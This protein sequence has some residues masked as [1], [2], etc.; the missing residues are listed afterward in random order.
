M[1]SKIN[2]MSSWLPLVFYAE[3][4]IADL[5]YSAN[6]F[7]CLGFQSISNYQRS[8]GACSNP[9]DQCFS[10]F[11]EVWNTFLSQNSSADHLTLVP[12]ERKFVNFVAYFK[13]AMVEIS[14]YYNC[15]HTHSSYNNYT[16]C[17]VSL[18]SLTY[19]LSNDFLFLKIRTYIKNLSPH[20]L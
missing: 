19:F 4:R 3:L 15:W 13:R 17:K 9:L 20:K 2:K 16:C 1:T 14:N 8:G 18:M 12:F 7:A 6:M 5:P 10:N 11:F